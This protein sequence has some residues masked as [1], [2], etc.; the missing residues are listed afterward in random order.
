MDLNDRLLMQRQAGRVAELETWLGML[1]VR[2]GE[3]H[4][5]GWRYRVP[6]EVL[7]SLRAQLPRG[8]VAVGVDYDLAADALVLD[9][10]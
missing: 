2:H 5:S 8:E 6:A 3:P 9:V 7:D 10:I 4:G 1:V